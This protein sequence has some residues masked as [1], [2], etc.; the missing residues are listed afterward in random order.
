MDINELTFSYSDKKFIE[1]LSTTI[2]MGKVT[3]I[4][5]P[6]GSGKS[7]LLNL[8]VK[9]LVPKSGQVILD[10]KNLADSSYKELSKQLAIVHQYNHAPADLT[11]E[12]LVGYG[13]SPYQRFWSSKGSG[14]EEIIKWSLKVTRL[15]QIAQ[16]PVSQLSGGERQRAWIAMAL[17]QKTKVLLLDEPTTYLDIY[18]QLEILALV[19]ELNETY[20]ITVVMVLHDINQAIQ[21]SHNV[22]IMKNGTIHYSGSVKDGITRERLKEV[23]GICARIGWCEFNKCPYIVPILQR[24]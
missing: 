1:N 9:Q 14:D 17:A 12:R 23:Y 13:R 6:N 20:G 19:K 22:V 11:V 3:T 21:F 24:E 15:E 4:I 18:Y 8:I 5:G 7:T 2:E 16:K 10:G